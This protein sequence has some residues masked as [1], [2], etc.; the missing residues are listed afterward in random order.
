M[1]DLNVVIRGNGL[2]K[3]GSAHFNLTRSSF[4]GEALRVFASST[5]RLR[6]KKKKQKTL[7]FNVSELLRN[8]C[9]PKTIC[10][11]SRKLICATTCSFT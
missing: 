8:K 3:N 2:D 5:T 11:P 10:F 1:E 4:K 6:N 7:I 9:S